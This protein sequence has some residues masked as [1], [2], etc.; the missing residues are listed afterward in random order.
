MKHTNYIIDDDQLI[1]MIDSISGYA[2]QYHV[3]SYIKKVLRIRRLIT[4][5]DVGFNDDALKVRIIRGL[6]GTLSLLDMVLSVHKDM[7]LEEVLDH[8]KTC[9]FGRQNFNS[10]NINYNNNYNNKNYSSYNNNNYKLNKN[11]NYKFNNYNNNNNNVY[12]INDTTFQKKK[13]FNTNAPSTINNS[14]YIIHIY[15]VKFCKSRK[16]YYICQIMFSIHGRY[17]FRG[18]EMLT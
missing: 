2:G 12:N 3:N 13:N 10:M 1:A 7:P 4:R 18:G 9:W 14:K 8:I 16:Q 5:I 11:N 15:A 6:S 17:K